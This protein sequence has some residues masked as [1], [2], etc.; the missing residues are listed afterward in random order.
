MK[1][2]LLALALSLGLIVPA[3]AVILLNVPVTTAVT[4]Q[5][6]STFQIRGIGA[7]VTPSSIAAQG[8]A[9]GTGGST[10]VWWLQTSFDGGTTWCDALTFSHAAAGRASGIVVSTPAAG[11]APAACTDGALAAPGVAPGSYAGQWRVKYTTTGTWTAG[12][13]RIDVFG[14]SIVPTP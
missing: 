5:V 4:A 14:N 9:V 13:L 10:M 12:N 3:Q 8:T 7:G 11:A 6:S 2:F 1:K